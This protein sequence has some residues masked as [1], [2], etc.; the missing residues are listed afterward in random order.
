MDNSLGQEN[1]SARGAAQIAG[2]HRA[3]VDIEDW[4]GEEGIDKCLGFGR[5]DLGA[6]YMFRRSG[7]CT[8]TS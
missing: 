2:R 4:T 5:G 7:P 1:G 6:D 8:K 3:V